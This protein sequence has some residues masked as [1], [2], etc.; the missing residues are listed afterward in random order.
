MLVVICTFLGIGLS[1]ALQVTPIAYAGRT[2]HSRR[3]SFISNAADVA[4]KDSTENA[5]TSPPTVHTDGHMWDAVATEGVF[6]D[7][8]RECFGDEDGCDY[9]IAPQGLKPKTL[10]PACP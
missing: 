7:F 1:A 4:A 5:A 8:E 9:C 10:D 6:Q 3:R 2:A